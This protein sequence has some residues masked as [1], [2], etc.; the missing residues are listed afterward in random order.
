[1]K[2]R[3]AGKTFEQLTGVLASSRTKRYRTGVGSTRMHEPETDTHASQLQF[4][5]WFINTVYT[6]IS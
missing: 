2:C 1:M 3:C 6:T 5:G 4:H